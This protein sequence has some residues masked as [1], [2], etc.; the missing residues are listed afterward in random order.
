[1]P[2]GATSLDLLNT[3]GIRFTIS[4]K[5]SD[6]YTYAQIT[7]G[8]HVK[9]GDIRVV[10]GVDKVSSWG[11]ATSSCKFGQTASCVFKHD[12]NHSYTWECTG[13]SGRVGPQKGEIRDLKEDNVDPENQCLFVRTLSFNLSGVTRYDFS[14]DALQQTGAGSGNYFGHRDSGSPGSRHTRS[15]SDSSSS[16]QQPLSMQ[17]SLLSVNSDPVEQ[18]GVSH[19]TL[20]CNITDNLT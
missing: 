6:W 7:R 15:G 13:A 18:A 17:G 2:H 9:D 20:R 5:A 10:V 14:P 3:W 19:S 16:S 4:Q 8:R 11:I 12:Q 1:M